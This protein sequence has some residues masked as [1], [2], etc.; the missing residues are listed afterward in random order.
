[1]TLC[2]NHGVIPKSIDCCPCKIITMV[3]SKAL[4][5]PSYKIKRLPKKHSSSLIFHHQNNNQQNNYRPLSRLLSYILSQ[6][7]I[8]DMGLHQMQSYK[9]RISQQRSYVKPVQTRYVFRLA[10]LS[11]ENQPPDNNLMSEI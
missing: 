2:H 4:R 9:K 8:E 11:F 7:V 3:F 10:G 5:R 6:T 1:M